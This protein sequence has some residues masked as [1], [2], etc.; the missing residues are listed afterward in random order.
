MA[1]LLVQYLGPW[2]VSN[3]I[4]SGMIGNLLLY[5][6]GMYHLLKED[7]QWMQYFVLIGF[8]VIFI[9]SYNALT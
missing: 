7:G 4:I 6:I 2:F 3:L 9:E 5:R 8:Y 1:P